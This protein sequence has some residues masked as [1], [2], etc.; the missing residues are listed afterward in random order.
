MTLVPAG[1]S[2]SRKLALSVAGNELARRS[3][4][5]LAKEKDKSIPASTFSSSSSVC[6]KLRDSFAFASRVKRRS[7]SASAIRGIQGL[8]QDFRVR[9]VRPLLKHRLTDDR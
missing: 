2:V 5:F 6:V 4:A 9:T 1:S 3:A 8:R 7:S